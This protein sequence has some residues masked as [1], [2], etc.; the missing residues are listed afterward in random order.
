MSGNL[1]LFGVAAL[2]TLLLAGVATI[3]GYP[4]QLSARGSADD[5]HRA[6]PHDGGGGGPAGAAERQTAS[7]PGVQVAEG[8][9]RLAV[10]R[11]SFGRAAPAQP[12][13]F[14]VLDA[15]GD[16]VRDFEVEH[17]KRMH[18]IVVRR[19]LAGFQHL[20]PTMATDGTWTTAVNFDEAGTYRVFADTTRDGEQRTL[21]ADVQVGGSFAPRALPPATPRAT[22]GGGLQVELRAG[23]ASAGEDAR[24]AF[25]VQDGDHEVTDRLQPYLGAKGHLVTLRE[26]DLAYLHTHPEADELA[27]SVEYPSAGRYRLFAQFRYRGRVQ[28][29]AFTQDVPE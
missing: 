21:G 8:G 29:A 6:A 2:L 11:S 22:L 19:D 1:R 15:E 23:A 14:R 26:G 5:E 9:L 16:P 17:E 12:F 7:V 28:T 13:S 10:Q 27:F 20:H 18:F 24:L 4:A 25:V 3:A